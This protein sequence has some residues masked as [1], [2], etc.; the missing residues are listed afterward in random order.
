MCRACTAPD[1][2]VADLHLVAAADRRGP[3]LLH[4]RGQHL[5][6]AIGGPMKRVCSWPHEGVDRVGVEVVLVA[7]RGQAGRRSPLRRGRGAPGRHEAAC[8]SANRRRTGTGRRRRWCRPGSSARSRPGRATRTPAC[9]VRP[10][11]PRISCHSWVELFMASPSA[12]GPAGAPSCAMASCQV[13]VQPEV[14]HLVMVLELGHALSRD[15]LQHDRLRP[16]LRQRLPLG[17]AFRAGVIVPSMRWV[18]RSR[19]R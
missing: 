17:R 11:S 18:P 2:D 14:V 19:R 15:R 3:R 13:A 4:A 10:R 8:T 1:A 9:P 12:L 5:A 6:A 16:V 7:V